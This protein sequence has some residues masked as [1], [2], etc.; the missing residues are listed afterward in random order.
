MNIRIGACPG[1]VTCCLALIA[2]VGSGNHK[3]VDLDGPGSW[4]PLQDTVLLKDLVLVETEIRNGQ[5]HAYI[6]DPSGKTHDI[7]VGSFVGENTGWVIEIR[8]DLLLIIQVVID[9]L[10]GYKE[11]QVEF[12]KT[13]PMGET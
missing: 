3:G 2:C 1:L 9:G 13:D 12:R 8:Q 4:G 7:T 11:V 10:G 6:R 5:W